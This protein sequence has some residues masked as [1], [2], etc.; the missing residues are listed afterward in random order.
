ME[1]ESTEKVAS[2]IVA[3]AL[4]GLA[5]VGSASFAQA[6]EPSDAESTSA[7]KCVE[8]YTSPP[9]GHVDPANCNPPVANRTADE[10]LIP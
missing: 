5:V 9:G 6:E 4:L 10:G 8:I 3:L 1:R 7:G 2:M